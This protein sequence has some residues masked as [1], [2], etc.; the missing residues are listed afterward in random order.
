MV[1]VLS[2]LRT[3]E[4]GIYTILGVL[5]A[6][7][8]WKFLQSWEELRAAAFGLEREKAQSGIN[9]SASWL[10]LYLFVAVGE[11]YVVSFIVPTIPEASPLPTPTINLQVTAL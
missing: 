4:S 3:Y 7:Q 9:T 1:S 8:V 6:W 10:L 2:F 11:F 5:A